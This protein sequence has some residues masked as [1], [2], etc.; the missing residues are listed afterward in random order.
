MHIPEL[1]TERKFVS[2][3]CHAHCPPKTVA[4]TVLMLLLRSRVGCAFQSRF[5][6]PLYSRYSTIAFFLCFI[7]FFIFINWQ[8]YIFFNRITSRVDLAM[9]IRSCKRCDVGS[10]NPS[11]RMNAE[12]LETIRARPVCPTVRLSVRPDDTS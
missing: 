9:S 4:P 3:E 10:Y 11:V 1:L 6:F 7:I 8:V 5:A 2:A 12:I